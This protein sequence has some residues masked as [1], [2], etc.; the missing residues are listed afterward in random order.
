MQQGMTREQ[1]W[2]KLSQLDR[3][4]QQ[5]V[6]NF[7]DSLLKPDSATN[8]RNKKDL[9]ALSVWTDEDFAQ[10]QE[11]QARINAWSFPAS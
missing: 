5:T 2:D 7:I 11:A 10:I 1:L 8:R 4:Q 9:L 6:A 3:F